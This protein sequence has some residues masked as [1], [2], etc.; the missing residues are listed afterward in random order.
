M[1]RALLF[2]MQVDPITEAE[3]VRRVYAW[4]D[5]RNAPVRLIVTPN[6]QHAVM[7]QNNPE[8]RAAYADASLALIDGT[9]LVWTLRLFGTAV[10]GRV[11]GSDLV[12][13]LFRAAK[14][15]ERG[16]SVYLLGAAPGVAERA[17]TLTEAEYPG[18][19]IVG[20][21]SPPLGFEK[22]PA[23]N[24][25]ILARVAEAA[26]ELLVVGF[27]AP[28]QELWSHRHRQK[29]GAR[30]AIC[31]GATIDFLAGNRPR[32]PEWMRETGTEWMHRVLT[33]PRRL[34]PRYA[35]DALAFPGL[36]WREWRARGRAGR[37]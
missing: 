4:T 23:E 33:E 30:V 34:G 5:E 29:L 10:P 6:V 18:V 31:A 35:A 26:P 13:A 28:K 14:A 2:G 37:I 22:D 9:P 25:R 21:Y 36:L 3:A 17:A 27:G 7:F 1:E 15:R 20:T 12:P 11:T 19:H 32:A 16:L 8:L 24:E